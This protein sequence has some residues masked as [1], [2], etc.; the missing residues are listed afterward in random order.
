MEFYFVVTCEKLMPWYVLSIDGTIY[1]YLLG[2][3]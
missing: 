2:Q 1:K 3:P